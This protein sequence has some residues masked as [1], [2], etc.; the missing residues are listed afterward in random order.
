MPGAVCDA[1]SND[2]LKIEIGWILEEKITFCSI[3]PLYSENHSYSTSSSKAATIKS[4]SSCR[5]QVSL[6]NGMSW[7]KF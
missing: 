2:V 7:S 4:S 5:E 1:L 3:F 6:P